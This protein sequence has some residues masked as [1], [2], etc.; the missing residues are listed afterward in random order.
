MN[1]R[2]RKIN[3]PQKSFSFVDISIFLL[4]AILTAMVALIFYLARATSYLS[5]DPRACINCHVMGPQYASWQ[6]SSHVRVAHCNDC[7]VPHDHFLRHYLFKASDGLRHA[8]IF[9]LRLEPQVIR[10]KSAGMR[11]VQENCIRCHRSLVDRTALI[12]MTPMMFTSPAPVTGAFKKCWDCHLETPHGRVNSLA[13]FPLARVPRLTPALP[14][15][16]KHHT[17]FNSDGFVHTKTQQ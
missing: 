8:T 10:I 1:G 11:V 14:E 2:L 9:T 5:D 4:L 6:R 13:S 12:Q 17:T 15:I 16:K 7:H 3:R